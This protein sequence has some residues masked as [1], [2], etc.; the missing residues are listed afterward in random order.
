MVLDIVVS[1]MHP[2]VA[3]IVRINMKCMSITKDAR[4]KLL[5]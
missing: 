4:V 5:A 2:I 1:N 3:K